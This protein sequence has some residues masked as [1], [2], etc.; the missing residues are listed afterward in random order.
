[1][2]RA[3]KWALRLTGVYLLHIVENRELAEKDNVEV[4]D[5]VV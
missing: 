1:M 5:E 3:E 2:E 4:A